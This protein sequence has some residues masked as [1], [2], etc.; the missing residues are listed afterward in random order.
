MK[1]IYLPLL[2]FLSILSMSV[3]GDVVVKETNWQ[4]IYGFNYNGAKTFIDLNTLKNSYSNPEEEFSSGSILIVSAEPKEI[5]I[6]GKT[7]SARS[8]VKY[9]MV[10]CKYGIMLPIYD[11]YFASTNPT[12]AE[13]PVIGYKYTGDAKKLAI[14]LTKSSP[15]YTT[16]CPKYI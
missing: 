2:I 7:Y 3:F 5:T 10:S 9:I 15:I 4:P 12:R 6:D 14:Q 8:A 13:T 1:N 16:M 11:L